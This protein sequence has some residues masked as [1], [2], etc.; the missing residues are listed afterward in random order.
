MSYPEDHYYAIFGRFFPLVISHYLYDA[1]QFVMVVV[2][3]RRGL[4]QF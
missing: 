2:L 3:I 1:V 4:I